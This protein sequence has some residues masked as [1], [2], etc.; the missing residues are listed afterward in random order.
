MPLYAPFTSRGLGHLPSLSALLIWALIRGQG[1]LYPSRDNLLAG[2][3]DSG[4][5]WSGTICPQPCPALR[6][7][8]GP[9]EV[10]SGFFRNLPA[11]PFSFC[12]SFLV[13][14]PT[15]IEVVAA[16]TPAPFNRYQAQNFTLVCI[17]SG[18]KPAPMVSAPG[19]A[20]PEPAQLCHAR[21]RAEK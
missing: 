7:R 4:T 20:L 5:L 2:V 13:A 9:S 21:E 14:P 11:K 6:M 10:S 3:G 19:T 17:V 1:P 15:S 16:D 8:P 18:G 12:A